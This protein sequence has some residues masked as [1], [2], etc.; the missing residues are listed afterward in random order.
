MCNDDLT[1][2]MYSRNGITSPFGKCDTQLSP[3]PIQD[4]VKNN[5][6][7]LATLSGMTLSEYARNVLT[8]HSIGRI[9]M[10]RLNANRGQVG[11]SAIHRE[12]DRP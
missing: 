2:P 11:T 6:I 10:V 7:T 4:E 5:L 1:D 8:E 12:N 9:A 3:I